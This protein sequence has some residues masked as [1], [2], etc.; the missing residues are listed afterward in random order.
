MTLQFT[1]CEK[2]KTT[3]LV[4]INGK[5]IRKSETSGGKN[6]LAIGN[7]QLEKAEKLP[8]EIPCKKCGTICKVETNSN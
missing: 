6:H 4:G 8:D 3:Y 2:C 7:D 5:D 1:T